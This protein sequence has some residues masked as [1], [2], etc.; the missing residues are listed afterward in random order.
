M[1]FEKCLKSCTPTGEGNNC[2]KFLL[3][4]FNKHIMYREFL[5]WYILVLFVI[6]LIYFKTFMYEFV[7]LR[8]P[9]WNLKFNFYGLQKSAERQNSGILSFQKCLYCTSIF[10]FNIRNVNQKSHQNE[11][12]PFIKWKCNVNFIKILH[13]ITKYHH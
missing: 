12:W 4:P 8:F 7:L 13:K 1:I 5:N 11:E 10:I 2:D 6:Y 9:I 3:A